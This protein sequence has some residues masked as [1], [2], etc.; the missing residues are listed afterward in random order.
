MH[1]TEITPP[2]DMFQAPHTIDGMVSS[3]PRIAVP[4]LSPRLGSRMFVKP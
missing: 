2:K 4:Q 1:Q 3:T